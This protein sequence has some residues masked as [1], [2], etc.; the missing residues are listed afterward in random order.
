MY[1]YSFIHLATTSK[2]QLDTMVGSEDTTLRDIISVLMDYG[3]D[4][5][6]T[7]FLW[8]EKGRM[9]WTPFCVT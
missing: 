9:L 2:C 8:I 3:P 7:T 4:L 6:H 1:L 5:S